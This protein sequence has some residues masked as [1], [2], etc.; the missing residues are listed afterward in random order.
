MGKENKKQELQKATFLISVDTNGEKYNGSTSVS[1]VLE[2]DYIDKRY[3]IKTPSITMATTAEYPLWVAKAI[4][5]AYKTAMFELY[6][7]H[8]V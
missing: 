2:I 1:V 6:T 4:E 7:L 8:G 3:T 5:K